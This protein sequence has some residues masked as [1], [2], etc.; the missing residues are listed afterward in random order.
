[1]IDGGGSQIVYIGHN[2]HGVMLQQTTRQPNADKLLLYCTS[3][4]TNGLMSH[5]V[6]IHECEF[7]P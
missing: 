3:M 7:D 2:P 1:M 4:K 6:Q 5:R